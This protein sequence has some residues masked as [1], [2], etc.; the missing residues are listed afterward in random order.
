[1]NAGGGVAAREIAHMNAGGGARRC[2]GSGAVAFRT[3]MPR[4]SG[5][6]HRY[7]GPDVGGAAR[8]SRV[9]LL[10]K[11]VGESRERGTIGRCLNR[12]QGLS[13]APDN[14]IIVVFV[15]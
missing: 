11:A 7:P 3:S 6:G 1:M 13:G 15:V 8:I 4:A 5:P 10:D 14:L 2:A 12:S 9:G